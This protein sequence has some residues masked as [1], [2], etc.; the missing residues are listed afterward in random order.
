VVDGPDR[1]RLAAVLHGWHC[2]VVELAATGR[3]RE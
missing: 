3:I 1:E 2:H